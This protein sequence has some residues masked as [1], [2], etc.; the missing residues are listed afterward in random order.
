MRQISAGA[1]LVVA[2][3]AAFI[4]AHSHRPEYECKGAVGACERG[5][6]LRLLPG[7]TPYEI[8]SGVA[9]AVV[10]L[11]GLVVV[12][13]LIRYRASQRPG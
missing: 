2:G 13:G 4:E 5:E 11:G 3:I 12:T 1:V 9:W 6:G 10:I 7:E 8:P